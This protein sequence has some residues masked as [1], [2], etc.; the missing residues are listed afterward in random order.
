MAIINGV[1]IL[2]TNIWWFGGG[3]AAPAIELIWIFCQRMGVEVDV[4]MEAVGRI[5]TGLRSPQRA[6]TVRPQ[7]RQHAASVRSADRQTSTEV[8]ALF[9]SAIEFAKAK[10]EAALL[11]ACHKIEAYFGF[12]NPTNS[13]RPQ[14][15]PVACTPTWWP[16]SSSSV[17]EDLLEDAMRLIPMVRR[18]A[19]LI[20]LV[21]PTSQIVGSRAVLVA[22]DRKTA[23]RTIPT[24]PTNSS[25]S[26]K[27]NTAKP[28][29]P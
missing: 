4:N 13:S 24:N 23:S 18:D 9:D 10:D 3:S 17:S 6:R 8:L 29:W 12:P 11:D 14:K 27:A 15:F 21:T 25:H 22:L 1:D 20:P 26:S 16:S 7:Q 5:R 2:D 28:R 19:G